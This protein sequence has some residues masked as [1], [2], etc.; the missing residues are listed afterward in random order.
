MTRTANDKLKRPQTRRLHS[1]RSIFH[2]SKSH[3]D[4]PGAV[5]S[6]FRTNRSNGPL[7]VFAVL[8]GVLIFDAVAYFGLSYLILPDHDDSPQNK[9]TNLVAITETKNVEDIIRRYE[10]DYNRKSKSLQNPYYAE[11]NK[12]KLDDA[13]FSLIYADRVGDF[14]QVYTIL[15]LIENAKNNGTNIDNNSYKLNQEN[16]EL[17]KRRADQQAKTAFNTTKVNS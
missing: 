7:T 9:T 3:G 16:R 17:I 6:R 13:Y 14:N 5:V 4:V 2:R 15:S 1:L 8:V 10:K 12:D 11:W